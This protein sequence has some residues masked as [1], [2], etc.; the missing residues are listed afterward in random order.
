[1]IKIGI[2]GLGFVGNAMHKSFTI[3]NVHINTYDK[4]KKTGSITDILETNIVF[5]CLPTP[6]NEITKSYETVAIDEVCYKLHEYK[7][8]G[9]VVIKSTVEPETTDKLCKTYTN[10]AFCHNPEFLTARTA[11]D[12]FHNQTHIVLGRGSNCND[13]K[14]SQLINFYKTTY[15]SAEISICSSIE[16]ES[17]KIMTNS[18]YAS[19][20]LLFNE[21]YLLCQKNGANYDAVK[22]LMLKNGW[23][24]PMHT[25][26][27]GHDGKLGYGGMCFPKD[28]KAFGH[29]IEK[30]K[31]HNNI[32]KSVI[33]TNN[34]IRHSDNS[35]FS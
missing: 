25:N 10:L 32:I 33:D 23:I 22:N 21:Y 6:Y 27:P 17:M 30:N 28:I 1:M 8:N 13:N 16:S 24:N 3:N 19:K 20:V 35:I 9:L 29:Y 18:F 12:D 4:Y 31:S 34:K 26:V 11:F 7:Y 14:M 2:V 5:L 15:P